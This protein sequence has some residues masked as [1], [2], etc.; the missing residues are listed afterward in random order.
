MDRGIS[1]SRLFISAAP[2][3]RRLSA[4][5]LQRAVSRLK[6]RLLQTTNG[7][8]FVIQQFCAWTKAEYRSALLMVLD[9]TGCP[10][11]DKGVLNGEFPFL[12]VEVAAAAIDRLRAEYSDATLSVVCGALLVDGMQTLDRWGALRPVF[13]T[14]LSEQEPTTS[15]AAEAKPAVN[16]IPK[17]VRVD[18][19][20]STSIQDWHALLERCARIKHIFD[21]NFSGASNIA[22]AIERVNYSAGVFSEVTSAAMAG[23][24]ALLQVIELGD[25]LD[26]ATFEEAHAA[27]DATFGLAVATAAVRG[28]LCVVDTASAQVPLLA[29]C[30]KTQGAVIQHQHEKVTISATA[31]PTVVNILVDAAND[32]PSQAVE[33]GNFCGYADDFEQDY[34]IDNTGAVVPAPWR[35]PG[36]P[37]GLLFIDQSANQASR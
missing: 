29:P 22:T 24:A 7:A 10:H 17:P 14:F 25:T 9:A 5:D 15:N 34:W 27:I 23:V 6:S 26:D 8:P 37:L 19:E 36:F 11:D 4:E 16:I 21:P 30:P 31:T 12:T 32:M 28:R 33:V 13:D 2:A 3:S 35:D 1:R 20:V 18:T